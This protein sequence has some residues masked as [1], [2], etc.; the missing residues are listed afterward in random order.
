[1]GGSE[2]NFGKAIFE[3]L[4]GEIKFEIASSN[5]GIG[6]VAKNLKGNLA[7]VNGSLNLNEITG[8]WLDGEIEGKSVFDQW[9]RYWGIK[10][11][12]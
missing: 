10:C 12:I 6:Q 2:A 3:G 7:L 4:D 9:G 8:E 11:S 5:L 1:M